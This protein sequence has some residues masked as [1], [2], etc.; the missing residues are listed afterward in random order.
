MLKSMLGRKLFSLLT[1]T[2]VAL[3]VESVS[4]CSKAVAIDWPQ[5]NGSKSNGRYEETAVLSKIPAEG[6]KKRWSAEVGL[7]YSGPVV[8]DRRVYLTDYVRTEGEKTN[9]PSVRDSFKGFERAHAFD[10]KTGN[11]LWTHEYPRN[12]SISY[13]SG[14]RAAPTVDGDSVYTLG[15]EGD[16]VS[17]E[18]S[19]GKLNWARQLRDDYKTESP[20]WGYSAVP[21]IYQDSIITL[22][23][24]NGSLVVA[25]DKQTGNEKWRSLSG[26]NIGYCPPSI[27]SIAGKDQLL[28][29]EPKSLHGLNPATGEVLWSVPMVPKYEMSIVPPVIAGDKMFVTGI[30]EVAAMFAIDRTNER[31]PLRELWRGKAKHAIYC[32]NS[33][34]VFDGGYLYGADCEKGSLICVRA[35][36]GERMW[37]TFEPTCG[38]DRRMSHGTAFLTKV[39]DLYYLLSET[40]DFIIARLT[41]KAYEEVGRF[42]VLEATNECFGRSVVWSY[43]AY[44]DRCL[45]ARNDKE[46]VAFEISE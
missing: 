46:L 4:P 25:L 43:P 12:Y 2:G 15:A 35:Q 41:P 20:I 28:I 3:F 18:S 14:P 19:T 21:L 16:L 9:N 45:F 36:D 30:G 22:A 44:S 6:L 40:G 26:E 10:L 29:W 8:A 37:E 13:P 32:A 11:K 33:T 1:L 39:G 34:P 27:V 7:G 23:G 17:L 38:G 42:K 31:S 24:G 5:W